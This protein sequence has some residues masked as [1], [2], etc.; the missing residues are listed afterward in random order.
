MLGNF[1]VPRSP[2]DLDNSS[3]WALDAGGGLGIFSPA[4]HFSLF[5][6]SLCETAR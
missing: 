3:A 2:V 4:Y 1:P 6:L 5:S